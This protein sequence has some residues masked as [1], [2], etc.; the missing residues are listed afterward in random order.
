MRTQERYLALPGDAQI[1]DPSSWGFPDGTVAVQTLSLDLEAG[2]PRSRTPVET[3]ILV[4]QDEHWMGYT[5]LWN[6]ART[7]ATLVGANGADHVLTIKDP[8][9]PGGKPADRP[10]A[11]PAAASAC[12]A[13]RARPGSSWA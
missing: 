13:T 3:R 11:S 9:A 12:S 4:K 2:N 1:A 10:G 7:D 8:A 5:Y 6:D